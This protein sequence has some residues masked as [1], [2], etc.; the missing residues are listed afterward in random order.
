MEKYIPGPEVVKDELS[1]ARRA[2]L[3]ANN[4]NIT[5]VITGITTQVY[6]IPEVDIY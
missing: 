3:G 5:T 1:D 2:A 6:A 4:A